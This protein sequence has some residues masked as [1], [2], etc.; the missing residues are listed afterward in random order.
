MQNASPVPFVSQFLLAP[1]DTSD[2]PSD[3]IDA[4]SNTISF[5]KNCPGTTAKA[6]NPPKLGSQPGVENKKLRVVKN[7]SIASMLPIA[8]IRRGS[9]CIP[10]ITAMAIST[11]PE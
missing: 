9:Q 10:I 5:S 3:Q 2:A 6:G 8:D 7:I 1:M 4:P 11:T